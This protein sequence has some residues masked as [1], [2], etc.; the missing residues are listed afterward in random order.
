MSS[1]KYYAVLKGRKTGIFESWSECE[2]QIKGFIG[3]S[4][5]A[6]KNR[7]AAE[8]ALG[9]ISQSLLFPVE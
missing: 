2:E 9:I 5:K 8:E 3:A 6:F 4:Y 7:L 1:K